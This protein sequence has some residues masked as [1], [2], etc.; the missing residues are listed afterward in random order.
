MKKLVTLLL[1]ATLGL[2]AAQTT[3]TYATWDATREKADRKLIAAFEAANP[4]IKVKYNLVPWDTYW[5]KA[6]AMVAGG[7][8]FDVM[9]MDL[10][11]FP[12]YASQGA[13]EPI[14]LDAAEKAK[15]PAQSLAPYLIGDGS[16][17]YGLPLGP[18]AVCVFINRALFKERGVPI[19]TTGWTWDQMLS[20]AQ[21]LTFSKGGKRYWGI[22]GSDLQPD[23]EYGMSFYYTFGGKGIIQKTANGYTPNL[24]ATFRQTAQRLYDLIY[25]YKVSPTAND[26]PQAAY[27]LFQAGQ[28]GI[29][30]EGTWMTGVWAE[31]PG[32]DWAFAPFPTLKAGEPPRPLYSAHALVIPKASKQKSAAL[33]F[34]R[35]ITT[36]SQAGK[37]LAENGL[38]PTQPD[39]YEK[40]FLN[41][42]K[43]RNGE[44]IFQQLKTS[45]IR[46]SNLRTV[47][48]LP[49]VLN[50]L[51]ADLNL[52]WTGNLP[53]DKAIDKANTDM[54]AL[55]KESK[56]LK[57]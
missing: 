8:T 14:P 49:E 19:P 31:T 13:L 4:G 5:Q 7:V 20:A 30:V 25:K 52:A 17:T 27:Q 3:L 24:E 16:Q 39:P 55:L 37:I 18:Q 11:N 29:Y 46:F 9:W 34:A 21:K 54:G 45:E 44:V 36:S 28:L 53:L 2:A 26:T 6:S 57:Y 12:F 23:L 43:G 41:A 32:L 47:S 42:L 10:D 56:E 15:Y 50:A 33:T 40:L 51:N 38:L 35:W 1:A 48:N 22:N